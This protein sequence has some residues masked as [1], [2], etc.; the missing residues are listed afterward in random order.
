MPPRIWNRR[1]QWL[2]NALP[3]GLGIA[4]GSVL[5]PFDAAIRSLAAVVAAWIGVSQWGFFENSE[6]E[7][8]LRAKT[9]AEGELIGFVFKKNPTALDAHA[10]IGILTVSPKK[11]SVVT[12][13]GK[14]EILRQDVTSITK[15]RNIHSL[16][17]LGGWVVLILADGAQFKFESRKHRTMWQSRKRTAILFEEIRTWKRERAPA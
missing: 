16:I 3:L 8:E 2:G 11:L 10:E 7:Q 9:L 4:V 13:D 12:E 14:V 6:I 15:L 1:R 5:F 17:L